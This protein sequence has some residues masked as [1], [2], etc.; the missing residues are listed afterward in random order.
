MPK[1]L[2]KNV[3]VFNCGVNFNHFAVV[4]VIFYAEFLQTLNCFAVKRVEPKIRNEKNIYKQK[5]NYN[6]S[7]F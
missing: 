7:S 1:V 5:I 2:K 6:A 3:V 4:D